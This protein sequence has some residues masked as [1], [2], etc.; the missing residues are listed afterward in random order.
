MIACDLTAIASQ[1][2]PKYLML[3]ERIRLAIE[4]RTELPD[5]YSFTLNEA[6]LSLVDVAEWIEKERLC[7]PFLLLQISASG[8]EKDWRAD[9]Y[10]TTR[11]EGVATGHF[12]P[13]T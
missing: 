11:R 1:D 7:C 9:H 5:G 4:A 13:L 6:R 8:N 2:R 12:S 3:L 10:G